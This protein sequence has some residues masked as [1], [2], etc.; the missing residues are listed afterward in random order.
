M[1]TV[2]FLAA[3][4][5]LCLPC[6][7]I[8]PPL[9]AALGQ[10]SAA[11]PVQH[12][13]TD[14]AALLEFASQVNGLHGS[15]LQPWH[16]H[17][18]WQTLD[19]G[20]VKDHGAWEEWWAG[21]KKF[22]AIVTS[23]EASQTSYG[24]D[25]GA[26]IVRT[27]NSVPPQTTAAEATLTQPIP[28]PKLL[29]SGNTK[30]QI[31]RKKINGIVMDCLIQDFFLNDGQ[32]AFTVDPHGDRHSAGSQYCFSD[33]LPALR[34]ATHA[35]GVSVFNSIVRFQGQYLARQIKSVDF[36][37][38]ET[39]TAVDHIETLDPIVDSD[40]APP[41]D[42]QLV[43]QSRKIAVSSAVEAGNRIG[44]LPPT[45]PENAKMHGIQGTVVLH[46]T[47]SDEGKITDLS[48]ISG[49]P[50]LQAAAMAAVRTWQYRPYLLAGSP[51]AVETQINV[52]YS[53]AR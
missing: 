12:L 6:S 13:P 31:T 7:L 30:L 42:A 1:R 20:Q 22:K 48:V 5:G 10:S 46:A 41:A 17:A 21:E 26:F 51:V 35:G 2:R 34:T 24:T 4:V 11:A 32:I 53:L 44:G 9:P 27:S 38:R 23:S 36:A 39:D 8:C 18:T 43:Q 25:H 47:I 16:V 14:P 3:A 50:E 49:P 15:G 33:N 40:F 45:Y 19:Q 29:S 28:D 52:I 37:G